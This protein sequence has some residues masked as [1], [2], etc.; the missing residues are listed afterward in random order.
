MEKRLDK[1]GQHGEEKQGNVSG[2]GGK[3]MSKMTILDWENDEMMINF[4]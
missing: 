3:T 4:G 1:M 2:H